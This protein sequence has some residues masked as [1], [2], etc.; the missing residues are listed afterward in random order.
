[1]S[2]PYRERLKCVAV[3][4]STTEVISG[5]NFS[6]PGKSLLAEPCVTCFPIWLTL[7]TRMNYS[8]WVWVFRPICKKVYEHTQRSLSAC[9]LLT[10]PLMNRP[11]EFGWMCECCMWFWYGERHSLLFLALL[12]TPKQKVNGRR[13]C[14]RV[15]V[16]AVLIRLNHSWRAGDIWPNWSLTF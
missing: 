3:L 12:V 1:M 13:L 4:L 10:P 7:C 14:I 6:L 5:R 15:F 8:V 11:F 2:Q 9:L 16:Q